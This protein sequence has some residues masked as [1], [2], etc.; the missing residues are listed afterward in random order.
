M[1][2]IAQPSVLQLGQNLMLP[3]SAGGVLTRSSFHDTR[4]SLAAVSASPAVR[5][6]GC[7]PC[8][9]PAEADDQICW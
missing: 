6:S 2:V 5:H 4:L 1:L 3:A 8:A 9:V 7:G